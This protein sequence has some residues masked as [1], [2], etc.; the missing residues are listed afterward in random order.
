MST[1]STNCGKTAAFTEDTATNT[2]N[3][4][5]KIVTIASD[6]TDIRATNRAIIDILNQIYDKL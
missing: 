4:Y 5:D 2:L 6:T 3:I 1:I